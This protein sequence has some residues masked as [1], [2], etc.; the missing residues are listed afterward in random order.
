MKVKLPDIKVTQR[1]TK[2]KT[3]RTNLPRGRKDVKYAEHAEATDGE[4]Q[5]ESSSCAEPALSPA[6]SLPE[7]CSINEEPIPSLHANKTSC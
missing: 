2:G 4:D 7:L 1:A 6:A 3:A 5:G